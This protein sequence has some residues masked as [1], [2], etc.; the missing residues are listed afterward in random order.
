MIIAGVEIKL[1]VLPALGV[2]I[3]LVPIQIYVGWHKSKTGFENVMYTSKRVHIMSEILTAIKLIKFY[4]WE[5]PFY[6]RI[7]SIRKNELTQLRKNQIANAINYTIVF[8]VPVLCSLLSLLTFWQTGGDV[9]P[10]IGFTIV[11]VY[12][13]LRYPLL[14]AP[15]AINSLSDAVTAATRLDEFFAHDEIQE[16]KRYPLPTD[17]EVTI[18]I[19]SY[20]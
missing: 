10:V 15:Q 5:M 11:S 2:I 19:V 14:M 3:L 7:V 16:A 9:T 13:T 4:A 6:D 1:S 8:C 17:S 20:L 12:N 18:S